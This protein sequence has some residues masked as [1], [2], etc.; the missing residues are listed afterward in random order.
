MIAPVELLLLFAAGIAGGVISG[1][2]GIGGGVIYVLIFSLYIQ[3]FSGITISGT[4]MVSLLI[5]NSV[6]ALVFA[7]I[8]GSLRQYKTGNFHWQPILTIAIPGIASSVITAALIRHVGLYDKREFAVFFTLVMIPVI[9]KMV[10]NKKTTSQPEKPTSLT[11]LVLLGAFAGMVT[12]LSGLGGGFIIVPVLS[13]LFHMPMKKAVS[14]SLGVIASVAFCFSV[15]NL[16]LTDYSIYGFTWSMGAILFPL[17]L[18][19]VAGVLIGA[20]QGVQLSHRLPNHWH[21]IIFVLFT[22]GVIV[23]LLIDFL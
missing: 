13:T 15:Y 23:K 12:A 1:L 16:T 9:A 2:L 7:G 4:D 19:V 21:R 6:F 11:V 3:R 20:P 18:P 8:S 17:V 5:A 10:W 22:T 14:I